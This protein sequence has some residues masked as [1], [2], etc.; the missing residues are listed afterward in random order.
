MDCYKCVECGYVGI[1][2]TQESLPDGN[3]GEFSNY[4]LCP[5]CNSFAGRF[6]DVEKPDKLIDM[7]VSK[8]QL[9]D[10]VLFRICELQAKID[11]THPTDMI[12]K[13]IDSDKID[14]LN[15]LKEQ[16]DNL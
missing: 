10:I 14:E 8:Q 6:Y 9:I 4:W 1:D 16:I 2:F 3:S 11:N 12:S 7:L 15:N 5:E 13:I